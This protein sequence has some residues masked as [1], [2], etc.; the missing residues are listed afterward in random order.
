MCGLHLPHVADTEGHYCKQLS[1][2]TE[3]YVA[4][5]V[6][7]YVFVLSANIFIIEKQ[8]FIIWLLTA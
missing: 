1:P 8:L 6:W 4:M 2:W 5:Q 7:N 3:G